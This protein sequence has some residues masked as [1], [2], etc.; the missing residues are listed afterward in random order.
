[1]APVLVQGRSVQGAGGT[2]VALAFL[3]SNVVAGN[4]IIAGVGSYQDTPSGFTCAD[5][6]SNPYTR[7]RVIK[8]T[9]TGATIFST[10]NLVAAPNAKP[11]V[12]V[13]GAVAIDKTLMIAEFSGL[14]TAA[15][16]DTGN[17]GTGASSPYS[18]G[19]TA[20]LAQAD[21]LVCIVASHDGAGVSTPTAAGYTID[22]NLLQTDTFNMPALLGYKVVSATTAV[23][24]S[25][26]WE[27]TMNTGYAA[28][29]ATY[30]AAAAA[31]KAPPPARR[32]M[33]HLLVR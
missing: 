22:A 31:T 15:I 9:F 21:E 5:N 4:A 30:K 10:P 11:T 19:T 2:S 1:M 6:N 33:Q 23:T 14:L 29:I 8:G 24:A 16:A 12:T 18:P 26:A 27:N 7:D 13:T 32:S 17:T 20:T 3:A 25:I 28:V